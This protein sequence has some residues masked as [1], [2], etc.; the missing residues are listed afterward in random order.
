MQEELLLNFKCPLCSSSEYKGE[1]DDSAGE[2]EKASSLV[3]CYMVVPVL[4]KSVRPIMRAGGGG[5]KVVEGVSVSDT[6]ATKQD[7]F[8]QR[9]TTLLACCCRRCD[10]MIAQSRRCLSR[11]AVVATTPLEQ[12]LLPLRVF[13][14]KEWERETKHFRR[15]R[16]FSHEQSSYILS[17]GGNHRGTGGGGGAHYPAIVLG[18]QRFP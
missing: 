3:Q 13:R 8:L 14:G 2:K 5:G 12:V 15:R 17:S 16:R 6:C 4:E 11:A 18:F 1:D 9:W 7:G 10:V